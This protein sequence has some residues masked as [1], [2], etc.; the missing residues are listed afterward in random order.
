MK[1]PKQV[2]V[3][4]VRTGEE[5]MRLKTMWIAAASMAVIILVVATSLPP[6]S[7]VQATNILQGMPSLDGFQIYFTE[8]GGEASRFDRTDTGLSRL[9]GLLELQGADLYTLEWRNGV[10]PDADLLI[11]AGPT[12][13]FTAD[14]TAWLWAYLQEGGHVLLIAEPTASTGFAALKSNSGLVTLL[15]DDMGIRPREDVVVTEGGT[16]FAVPPGDRVGRDTP[17]PTPL[18]AVEQT[19]LVADFVTTNIAGAH[20]ILAGIEGGLAFFGAR[21]L[22]VDE[23]PSLTQVTALVMSDS[24]FYGETHYADYLAGAPTDYNIGADTTRSSLVLAAALANSETGTRVVVI[25]DRDFVT[26]GYGLQTSP[27]YSASFLYPDNVRFLLNSVSW[28]LGAEGMVNMTFAT[29]GPTATPTMVPSATPVPAP[30][31]PEGGSS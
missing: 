17:T 12:K 4:L 26:N 11:I 25:G 23:A 7:P 13:D 5:L 6:A 18:P 8:T 15:W 19:A 2:D 31:E 22:E 1:P 3:Y 24:S 16:R 30:T 29:P 28:L 10:P 14:Q 27:P 20:P 9:A 21:S